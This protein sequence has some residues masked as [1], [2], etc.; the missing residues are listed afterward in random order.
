MFGRVVGCIRWKCSNLLTAIRVRGKIQNR[1]KGIG[2]I[3]LELASICRIKIVI[4]Y[5]LLR[6]S[7]K[8]FASDKDDP[9]FEGRIKLD[10]HADTFVSGRNCLL[11][12]Y[13]ERV[14]DVM[15][16]SDDYEAKKSVPIVQV[17]TGYTNSG[18]ERYVLIINE[19]IW[20]P[21]LENSLM[22]PNQLGD[23]GVKVQ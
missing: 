4:Y 12:H 20:L 16:Y 9:I 19:A 6:V 1:P 2:N 23:F 22:N 13:T 15:P 18:G 5:K 3:P 17:A 8:V 14:F 10:T 7:F 21:N 11:M